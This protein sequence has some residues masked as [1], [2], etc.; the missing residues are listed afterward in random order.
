MNDLPSESLR[1]SVLAS[2]EGSNLQALLDVVHKKHGVEIVCVAGDKPGAKALE[3]AL[4]AG[5]PMAIFAT[6]DFEDRKARDLAMAAHLRDVGTDL[7]VL[8]GYMAI[9]SEEFIGAFFGRI[10]NVHPSLLPKYPGLRAIEQA[11][12][13]G[14]NQTGVTVHYVDEGVDTG[15]VIAQEMVGIAPGATAEMLAEQIHAVE[16]RLLPEVVA[17]IAAARLRPADSA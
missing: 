5:I 9:L 15:D 12:E 3:R 17:Q 14:E 6:A 4:D 11:L 10:I 8:A 13:A 7:V 16:H 2:G 1:V